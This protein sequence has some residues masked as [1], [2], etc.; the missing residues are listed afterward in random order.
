MAKILKTIQENVYT[1][2]SV[3]VDYTMIKESRG[4]LKRFVVFFHGKFITDCYKVEDAISKAKKYEGRPMSFLD[5]Q[6]ST[7]FSDLSAAEGRIRA[8]CKKCSC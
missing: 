7:L 4:I 6:W 2:D 8:S 3:R 1:G 5:E